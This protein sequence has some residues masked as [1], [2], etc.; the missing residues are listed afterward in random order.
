MNKAAST[1]GKKPEVT[2]GIENWINGGNQ[3]GQ[4]LP[5]V[6]IQPASQQASKLDSLEAT[7]MLSVRIPAG[8]HHELR[9]HSVSTDRQIQE[10][11]IDLLQAYLHPTE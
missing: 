9:V 1:I 6:P 4:A 10:I 8:L 11:V 3:N 7:K 5:A 2:P